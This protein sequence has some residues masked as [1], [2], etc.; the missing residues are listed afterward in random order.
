MPGRV[1][2]GGRQAYYALECAVG[3][4]RHRRVLRPGPEGH[5]LHASSRGQDVEDL[6]YAEATFLPALDEERE[7]G[8]GSWRVPQFAPGPVFALV[9]CP[10]RVPSLVREQPMNVARCP[11]ADASPGT[12]RCRRRGVERAVLP[13]SCTPPRARYRADH[14]ATAGFIAP[15]RSLALLRRRRHRRPGRET[16]EQTGEL[17]EATPG[18]PRQGDGQTPSQ[19]QPRE[20]ERPVITPRRRPPCS[21]DGCGGSSAQAPA[22]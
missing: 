19:R 7:V 2:D 9:D 13:D 22:R 12:C 5:F 21:D 15:G 17:P 8:S 18:R 20:D 4:S 10:V 6:R 14:P 16:R 3:S 1:L 11:T